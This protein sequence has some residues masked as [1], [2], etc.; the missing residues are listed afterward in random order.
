MFWPCHPMVDPALNPEQGQEG[1]RPDPLNTQTSEY[2][3]RCPQPSNPLPHWWREIK[4]SGRASLG[5]HIMQEGHNDPAAQHFTLWQAAA[6]R[7]PVA[8]Q[9]ASG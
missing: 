9:E 5:A 7:L 3:T 1:E 6:F 2:Q 4:A 8:Q